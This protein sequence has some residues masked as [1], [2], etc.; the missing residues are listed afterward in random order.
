MS[1]NRRIKID[2]LEDAKDFIV[3]LIERIETLEKAVK[4]VYHKQNKTSRALGSSMHDVNT[5]L[6]DANRKISQVSKK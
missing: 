1:F 5:N 3:E 2:S 4:V 6:T